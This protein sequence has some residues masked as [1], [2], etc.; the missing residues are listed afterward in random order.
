MFDLVP[1]HRPDGPF[2][3]FRKRAQPVALLQQAL[4][5]RVAV[6]GHLLDQSESP[7]RLPRIK[8]RGARQ[9]HSGVA[10]RLEERAAGLVAIERAAQAQT[11]ERLVIE[12]AVLKRP[13]GVVT[14]QAQRRLHELIAD[15][16]FM[17]V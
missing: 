9:S 15:Q 10:A 12:G 11:H 2:A 7:T 14:Q 8:P 17:K 6:A 1:V 13:P 5:D 16:I 4:H 3:Q